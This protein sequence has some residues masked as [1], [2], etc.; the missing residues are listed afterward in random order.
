MTSFCTWFPIESKIKRTITDQ[1]DFLEDSVF[2]RGSWVFQFFPLC[3][4]GVGYCQS[5]M[6]LSGN[7]ALKNLCPLSFSFFPF[8]PFL[9]FHFSFPIPFFG[10]SGF[11]I[12][13]ALPWGDSVVLC[14]EEGMRILFYRPR[15]KKSKVVFQWGLLSWEPNL[16]IW[17][18][19]NLGVKVSIS[20]QASILFHKARVTMMIWKQRAKL[21]MATARWALK[22]PVYG[23]VTLRLGIYPDR[24]N[25]SKLCS[26]VSSMNS[27]I[28]ISVHSGK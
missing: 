24:P 26:F 21:V 10:K 7:L 14:F 22:H 20:G 19:T 27:S 1:L 28:L 17:G 11:S 6:I 8:L 15:F 13:F 23:I 25:V 16:D 12:L 5:R 2:W 4:C 18:E 9:S 3:S